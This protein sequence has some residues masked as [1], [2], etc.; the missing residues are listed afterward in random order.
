M[1]F[2]WMK[3]I[4]LAAIAMVRGQNN[5]IS[6]FDERERERGGGRRDC[7][8]FVENICNTVPPGPTRSPHL[9]LLQPTIRNSERCPPA[10]PAGL[11]FLKKMMI[12]NISK[13]PH[14]TRINELNQ[15]HT[16]KHTHYYCYNWLVIKYVIF[17]VFCISAKNI[18][19]VAI[20]H[21]ILYNKVVI[22]RKILYI[23]ICKPIP[24]AL[25]GFQ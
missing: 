23:C 17:I 4:S 3:I 10:Q 16:H 13:Q 20:E 2:H 15:Q 25:C 18:L 11:L 22:A 7:P 9:R 12:K 24:E 14:L 1:K 8:T 19:F 6:F 21:L 5:E